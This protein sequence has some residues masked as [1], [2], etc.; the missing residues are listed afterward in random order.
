MEWIDC[1]ADQA[2]LDERDSLGSV[3]ARA[4]M[5]ATFQ[6]EKLI[7]LQYYVE[8]ERLASILNAF[9]KRYGPPDKTSLL[10]DGLSKYG[11]WT[12]GDSELEIEQIEIYSLT[13][14]AGFIRIEKQLT[15]SVVRITLLPLPK[16]GE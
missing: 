7:L 11:S 1:A 6:N 16:P 10:N 5:N 15:R 13:E 3:T 8:G 14:G 4:E 9:A 2:P 12:Y